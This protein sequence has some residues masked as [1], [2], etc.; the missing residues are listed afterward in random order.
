MKSHTSKDLT[1]VQIDHSMTE[2][3]EGNSHPVSLSIGH[4]YI[5][6]FKDAPVTQLDDYD[7]VLENIELQSSF[8]QRLL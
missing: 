8:K 5:M 4:D 6:T 7:E 3:N 1:G 2:L